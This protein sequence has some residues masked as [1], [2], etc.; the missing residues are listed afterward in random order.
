[1]KRY[2]LTLALIATTAFG[3][4]S[5]RADD[6]NAMAMATAATNAAPAAPVA[7]PAASL[8]Q[9]VSALEAYI[10]N[11]D[12]TA[13]LKDTNGNIVVQDPI[14]SSLVNSTGGASP[15]PGPGHNAW[16]LTS[17]ALVLFM[18]LPGIVL[19]YGGLVRGKNVLSIAIQCFAIT[20]L[21]SV[22]WLACGYSLVYDDGGSL[23]PGIGGLGKAW[24]VFGEKLDT[25]LEE[26]NE[27][28]AA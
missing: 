13:P 11:G 2:L 1:M 28:L 3:L 4:T 22:L 12:P 14:M 19:F 9:R 17:T 16:L 8:D 24:Q 20:A 15:Y 27:K 10:E 23:Q 26:L 6:T 25:I 21:V 7:L 18:T 5:L